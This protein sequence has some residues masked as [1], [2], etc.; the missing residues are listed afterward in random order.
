MVVPCWCPCRAKPKAR[1][2][3]SGSRDPDELPGFDISRFPQV[4]K[5][6][7]VGRSLLG[8]DVSQLTIELLLT[9][10][11]FLGF[12][13]PVFLQCQSRN[14]GGLTCSCGQGSSQAARASSTEAR[15]G[16][17]V[18]TNHT[19]H[20]TPKMLKETWPPVRQT[21]QSGHPY[22][23]RCNNARLA[24]LEE[25]QPRPGLDGLP[26]GQKRKMVL[27]EQNGLGSIFFDSERLL[28]MKVSLQT[29]V[30]LQHVEI[31]R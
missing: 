16:S 1:T 4:G 13:A 14:K 22:P 15:A 18:G 21:E 2:S 27:A 12:I 9:R 8:H 30:H 3:S 31:R 29:A 11:V 20:A 24:K 19:P 17:R 28:G 7:A 5:Q 26:A 23:W 10:V 6:Q 25:T